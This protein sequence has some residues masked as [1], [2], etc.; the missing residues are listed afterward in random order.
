MKKFIRRATAGLLLAALMLTSA[1][2]SMAYAEETTHIHT[3]AVDT[4]DS[5]FVSEE[6]L[7]SGK[8]FLAT[9]EMLDDKGV[10]TLEGG[11]WDR[12]VITRDVNAAKVA[13][14]GVT[15]KELAVE[16]GLVCT[17][18]VSDSAVTN[19]EVVAPRLEVI[20]YEEL[21]EMLASGMDATEV[22]AA[23]KAYLAEKKA[24]EAI[25]PEIVIKGGAEIAAIKMAGNAKLNLTD[26]KVAEVKVSSNGSQE[27]MLVTIEGYQGTVSVAQENSSY[28]ILNLS[29]KN[30]EL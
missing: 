1:P 25:V 14:N 23:Y 6:E 7:A 20:G 21:C 8:V 5:L 18:E 17:F 16:S 13:L 27:R 24:V 11:E 9:A 4:Q 29:L 10:L 3:T 28:G 22:A 2:G 15:V 30:S 26:A 19:V 12:M